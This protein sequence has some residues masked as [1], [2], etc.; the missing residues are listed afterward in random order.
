MARQQTAPR[1]SEA[2]AK[3]LEP[4]RHSAAHILAQGVKRLWPTAR[5]GIGPPIEEGFYYDIELPVPVTDED[6]PKIEAQMAK[7]IRENHPFRQ[8]FK[9][10]LQALRDLEASGERFKAEI[11]RQLPDAEVSFFTDGEFTDLCAG[12]HVASTG[13][14]K[15]VKLLSV[16]GAYWRGDEKNPQLTRIYGT[17]FYTD[18][19]LQEFLRIREEA[20]RRDH[21]KLGKE[22]GLFTILDDAG[23]G[24]VFYLP[25]GAVVRQIIEQFLREEHARRGYLPVVTPH[26][27]RAGIWQRSGHTDYYREHMYVFKV[28]DQE[29]GIKP[30]NC[31]GHI[32]IYETNLRSYRQLPLRFFELGTVYR[33]E[34]SGV[35][36]GLLRVRGF[37]QDDAHI[38][39]RPTQ[40]EAEIG[41]IVRFVLDVMTVFGFEA[42][43]VAV[44]TRPEKFLGDPAQWAEAER[45]LKQVL[46]V[47]GVA[48]TVQAGE[49]AF[50][51]PKI[52]I[53]VQ[54]ALRRVWQCATIQ[55]DFVLPQRFKLTYVEEDGRPAAPV[56][57]HRA[58]LGSLERFLGMLI[59]HYAGAFPVWLAPVQLTVIPIAAAHQAYAQ[60]VVDRATALGIRVELDDRNER[61]QAKIRDA[62]VAKVPYMFV[63]GNR[64]QA[65]Q[66]VSVRT[67][68]GGDQGVQPVAAAL[69]AIAQAITT[70]RID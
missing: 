62:Q 16:A 66:G 5:L 28:E 2:G 20:R 60:A 35:L 27:L 63:V 34:K 14:V 45:I 39:C 9:P 11:V 15:A 55:L 46:D 31:P 30:M 54:D 43:D 68:A 53:K 44:S 29:F 37:T 13:E 61:M 42:F 64:E 70:R 59:E 32:L 6:L 48:Y 4:L 33:N 12:P 49:G 26:L 3:D 36:H 65:E 40:L 8:H 17:A 23:P 7:I 41:A 47:A 21:R 67:R 18:E 24:L 52:D 51:G 10:R 38:F 25:K 19:E 1:R 56:M 22:L 58:I 69:E 50:Y 57:I